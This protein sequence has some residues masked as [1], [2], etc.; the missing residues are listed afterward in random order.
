MTYFKIT[1]QQ[2]K[3]GET[4]TGVGALARQKKYSKE[5]EAGNEVP[6]FLEIPLSS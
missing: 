2:K 3:W 1:K 6:D 4:V 5:T